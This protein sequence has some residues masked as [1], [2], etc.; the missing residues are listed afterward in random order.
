MKY[1]ARPPGRTHPQ[2][3]AAI[4]VPPTQIEQFQS[5]VAERSDIGT[6]D[7]GKKR[8]AAAKNAASPLPRW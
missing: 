8:T 2:K 5:L 4:A 1:A 7:R 3:Q 6:H